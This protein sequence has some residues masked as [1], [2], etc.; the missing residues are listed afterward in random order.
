MDHGQNQTAPNK[1]ALG[2]S[3]LLETWPVSKRERRDT[4]EFSIEDIVRAAGDCR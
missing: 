3:L 4:Q 1:T 2:L